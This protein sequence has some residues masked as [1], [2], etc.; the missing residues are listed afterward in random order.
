MGNDFWEDP[1]QVKRFAGRDP[2]HRLIKL[3]PQY[4]EPEA[5]R[6]MDLGCAGGRNTVLL[7][8]KGF[9]FHAVDASAAMVAETVKRVAAVVGL[10]EAERRIN[11]ARMDGLSRYETAQFDLLIALGVLHNAGSQREWEKSLSE[12][13]RLLRQDGQL[14]LSNFGPRSQPEGMPLAPLADEPNVYRG[15]GPHDM[16]LLEACHLDEEM[17]RYGLE[18]STPTETVHT[19]TEGGFRITIN[20]LYRKRQIPA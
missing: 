5:V 1:E 10:K 12:V 14:M 13:S 19:E 16:Y 2:D 6:V 7:A 11:V 8:E 18:P 20:G 9:D 4:A 3:L 17:K 15:F